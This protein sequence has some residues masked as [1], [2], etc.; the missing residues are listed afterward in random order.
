M[1]VP[2]RDAEAGFHGIRQLPCYDMAAVPIKDCHEVTPTLLQSDVGDIH[3]PDMVGTAGDDASDEIGV[4][5]M[6]GI[7]NARIP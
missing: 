2:C 3:S 6:R 7:G 4:Y 5:S 1:R